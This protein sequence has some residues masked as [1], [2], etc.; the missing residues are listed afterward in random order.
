MLCGK[1]SLPYP[2]HCIIGAD[3]PMVVLVYALILTINI[4]VLKVIA[5][6]R[7]PLIPIGI[8]GF[9]FLLCSYTCVACSDPGIVYRKRVGAAAA[10]EVEMVSNDEDRTRLIGTSDGCAAEVVEVDA[11]ETSHDRDEDATVHNAATAVPCASKTLECGACKLQRPPSARHCY[12]CRTCERAMHIHSHNRPP[13]SIYLY[14]HL[15]IYLYIYPHIYLTIIPPMIVRCR[16]AR[17]PLPLVGKVHRRAQHTLLLRFPR[18][19][20]LSDLLP[21]RSL[22]LLLLFCAER[23]AK[24][25]FA[26]RRHGRGCGEPH[27]GATVGIA[28][29]ADNC[30]FIFVIS[31][32]VSSGLSN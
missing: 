23:R 32:C 22:H 16:R 25:A 12:F 17:S 7:S 9:C 11:L 28:S 26:G 29:W 20:M 8:F 27:R 19:S 3:W 4:V 21:H 18:V 30:L 13:S 14:I 10:Q 15:F 5:V 2:L 1:R 24:G 31:T 6:L